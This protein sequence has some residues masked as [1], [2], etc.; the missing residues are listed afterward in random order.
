MLK[1]ITLTVILA[2]V[3]GLGCGGGE[4]P[5]GP[6][7]L[8]EDGLPEGWPRETFAELSESELEAYADALPGVA[9]AL[10][11]VGFEPLESEPPDLVT[12]MGVTIEAMKA[13]AGVEDSIKAAGLSWD[14]FRVT[15]YKVMAAEN[16]M[17]LSI[18][19]AMAEELEGDE[20]EAARAEVARAQTVFGRVPKASADLLLEFADELRP[21]EELDGD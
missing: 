15:T 10:K 2:L 14:S 18:A 9:A 21:L 7:K 11:A 4:K 6:V 17:V 19:A 3:A 20:A 8:G 12:D 13:V 5:A 16:A 1:S